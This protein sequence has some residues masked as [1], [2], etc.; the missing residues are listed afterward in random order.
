MRP[1]PLM[2]TLMVTEGKSEAE[3]AAAAVAAGWS[4][5]EA[6]AAAGSLAALV[7]LAIP[8]CA[9]KRSCYPVVL[10]VSCFFGKKREEKT[11]SLHLLVRAGVRSSGAPL[12]CTGVARVACVLFGF[13]RCAVMLGWRRGVAHSSP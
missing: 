6:A 3:A 1:K 9:S 7:V 10:R 12:L 11:T 8:R 5:S 4:A 13:T 2:P